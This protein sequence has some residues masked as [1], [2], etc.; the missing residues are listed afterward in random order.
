MAPGWCRAGRRR[1]LRRGDVLLGPGALPAPRVH[2]A[3]YR[4][5][6]PARSRP[7]RHGGAA[8]GARRPD[9]PRLPV[10][11]AGAR[12][13]RPRPPPA[14][15]RV[16][17]RGRAP[18]ADGRCEAPTSFASE[19][20]DRVHVGAPHLVGVGVA[21]VGRR[22]HGRAGPR[23]AGP[24]RR[25]ISPRI[26][27][28]TVACA[29][30]RRG[31]PAPAR[32][33]RR[34]VRGVPRRAWPTP[35]A[36]PPRGSCGWHIP[37]DDLLG[38]AAGRCTASGSRSSSRRAGR[39]GYGAGGRCVVAAP[40]RGAAPAAGGRR[41]RAA[42]VLRGRR[43]GG[44]P[45]ARARPAARG[46]EV[47]GG[48]RGRRHLAGG[49]DGADVRHH[50]RHRRLRRRG[51]RQPQLLRPQHPHLPRPRRRRRL[52]PPD[53]GQGERRAG[54]RARAAVAALAARARGDGHQ[55]RPLPAGGGPLPA[56]AGHHR[57]ARPLR[58][59]VLGAHQGHGARAGPAPAAG[60]RG[61]RAGRARGVDR[62][63]G[64][65]AAGP[66]RAG[67]AVTGRPGWSWC[68]GSPTPVCRAG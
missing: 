50:H 41:P 38:S 39:P 7:R 62:A 16:E 53:R 3:S 43:P 13:A 14:R 46:P 34:L 8:A 44:E 40:A 18:L 36:S 42:A 37:D 24:G 26:R 35:S 5:G 49:R 45:A 25:R 6:I 21:G 61:G 56:D 30:A 57:R 32:P 65:G 12:G 64:P 19:A 33:G 31:R 47:D 15:H 23:R 28:G 4:A 51:R 1:R 67:H 2:T 10:R 9:R 22:G 60:G 58:H 27:R 29:R 52:R 48:L 63:A 20:A 11:P 17:W 68:A 66:A 54:A 59:A 55:H